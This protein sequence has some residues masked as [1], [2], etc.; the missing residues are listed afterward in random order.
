MIVL[1]PQPV[2]SG[3]KRWVPLCGPRDEKL[4]AATVD[5]RPL[6]GWRLAAM[7]G[8]AAVAIRIAGGL[9]RSMTLPA[10]DLSAPWVPVIAF[11]AVPLTF[12]LAITVSRWLPAPKRELGSLALGL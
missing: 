4:A 6:S 2:M 1:T 5:V 9:L 10:I 8:Y 11:A 3:K 12:M 7:L